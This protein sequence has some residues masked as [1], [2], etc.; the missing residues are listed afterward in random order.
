M[1]SNTKYHLQRKT[2][3]CSIHLL[4]SIIKVSLHL[5]LPR[6]YVQ[7]MQRER[8]DNKSTSTAIEEAREV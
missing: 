7:Q 8:D 6:F 3:R 2:I 1:F 5:L 4:Q